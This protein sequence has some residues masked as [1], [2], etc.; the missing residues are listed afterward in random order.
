M[1]ASYRKYPKVCELCGVDFVAWHKKGRYC[2][3]KCSLKANPKP[4]NSQRFVLTEAL[5]NEAES[6][7]PPGMSRNAY[8]AAKL[9]CTPSAVSWNRRRIGHY[10]KPRP[11]QKLYHRTTHVER[12]YVKSIGCVVCGER[13]LTEAAHLVPANEGG[14]GMVEN[15]IPLCPS[16]HRF[17]DRGLLTDA[18][19]TQLVDF[20]FVK[21]PNLR[22]KLQEVGFEEAIAS[23]WL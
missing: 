19:N 11:R 21:Y 1:G 17:Y 8:V 7:T 20:L 13:R 22:Q 18:E 15:I 6:S 16:H 12:R 3:N 14:P 10:W 2:S 5:L 4:Q 23:Q 9:G